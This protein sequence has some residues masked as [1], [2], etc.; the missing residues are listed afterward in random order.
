MPPATRSDGSFI[1][2]WFA[3]LI[4][5][6]V[7]ACFLLY[8][9]VNDLFGGSPLRGDRPWQASEYR[10]VQGPRNG[11]DPI[12]RSIAEHMEQAQKV[13]WEESLS[14]KHWWPWRRRF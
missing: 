4:A 12:D 7:L 14:E 9:V 10:K 5:V 11:I 3:L 1:D 2:G 13:E 6:G 8:Y